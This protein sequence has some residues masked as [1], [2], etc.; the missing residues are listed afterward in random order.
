VICRAAKL[1]YLRKVSSYRPN[2]KQE[3]DF[4]CVLMLRKGSNYQPCMPSS[5]LATTKRK[6]FKKINLPSTLE[7]KYFIL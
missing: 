3:F 7:E 4:C 6:I 5:R 1:L 2:Y